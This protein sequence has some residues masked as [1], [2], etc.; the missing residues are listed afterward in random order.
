[1]ANSTHWT[2]AFVQDIT[3]YD[4]NLDLYHFYRVKCKTSEWPYDKSH[5][6]I[7]LWKVHKSATQIE[8]S[9]SHSQFINMIQIKAKFE[10][11]E[12]IWEQRLPAARI[13]A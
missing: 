12:V 4:V 9:G 5:L 7:L 6:I 1:M 2:S 10:N 8:D 13:S 3:F 11:P